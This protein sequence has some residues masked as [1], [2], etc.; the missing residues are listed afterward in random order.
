VKE[1]WG[2]TDAYR[3]HAERTKNYSKQKWNDLAEEMDRIMADF[4]DDGNAELDENG[5][6]V[7]REKGHGFGTRSIVAFCEKYNSYYN[8]EAKE[9]S[10][11]LQIDF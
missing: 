6:P 10:F 4:A 5:I 3:E 2:K 1:K 9:D 11:V 8:F 7:T